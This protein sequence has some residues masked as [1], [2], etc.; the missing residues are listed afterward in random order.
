M[1]PSLVRTMTLALI[2]SS[3]RL[4]AAPTILLSAALARPSIAIYLLNILTTEPENV[5]APDTMSWVLPN[6]SKI[7]VTLRAALA[8]ALFLLFFK[9]S[10]SLITASGI[11]IWLQRRRKRTV[12]SAI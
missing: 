6:S 7:S 9:P 1:L 4:R 11:T 10:S 8:L 3:L 5:S 2:A 12:G